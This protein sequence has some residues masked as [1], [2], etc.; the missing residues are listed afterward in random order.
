MDDRIDLFITFTI[1]DKK[2]CIIL[3]NK[4][5]SP[6]CVSRNGVKQTKKYAEYI[7][8]TYQE[9]EK[10]GIYL[11]PQDTYTCAGDEIFQFINISY[12]DVLD[13][14]IQ[15]LLS[16]PISEHTRVFLSDYVKCLGRITDKKIVA[17]SYEESQTLADFYNKF[18]EVIQKAVQAKKEKSSEISNEVYKNLLNDSIIQSALINSV[19]EDDEKT[20][21]YQ[22]LLGIESAS[23]RGSRIN[24]RFDG[25]VIKGNSRLVEAI[26]K[27]WIKAN[28]K[29]TH[30]DFQ[31]LFDSQQANFYFS[32]ERGS[33]HYSQPFTFNGCKIYMSQQ[34]SSGTPYKNI[35]YVKDIATNEFGYKIEII[36][37]EENK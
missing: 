12:Q 35:D 20:I 17:I 30:L 6:E 27:K 24:Y 34:W 28:P 31:N 32:E 23:S 8:N 29:K 14:V 36:G 15:P 26:V 19:R 10:I 22:T 25:K 16:I 11:A 13:Y 37:Q 21:E 1:D 18:Q 7:K 4:I 33:V 9:Y 2:V 3:E 5:Y